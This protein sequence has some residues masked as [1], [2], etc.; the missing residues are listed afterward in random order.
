MCQLLNEPRLILLGKAAVRVQSEAPIGRGAN[1]SAGDI[2]R[3]VM[4][5]RQLSRILQEGARRGNVAV[6]E[7][8]LH[9]SKVDIARDSTMLA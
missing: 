6:S 2:D 9:G 7:E 8:L 4:A 1:L 5:R 3:Y